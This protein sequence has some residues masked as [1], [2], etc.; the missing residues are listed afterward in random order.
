MAANP[1]ARAIGFRARTVDVNVRLGLLRSAD[2]LSEEAAV[3]RVAAHSHVALDRENEEVRILAP[4]AVPATGAGP[5]GAVWRKRGS[6]ALQTGPSKVSS[7]IHSPRTPWGH[8]V[9]TVK[10]REPKQGKMEEIP[11][12]EVFVV[13]SYETDYRPIF[14]LPPTYLRSA[15][16]L[17]AMSSW[18]SPCAVLTRDAASCAA[19]TNQEGEFVEYDLDNDDED[20]LAEFNDGQERLQPEMCALVPHPSGR[21]PN[22]CPA[23]PGH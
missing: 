8:Q 19:P 10:A 11:T 23:P 15:C 17:S 18:P 14:R 21:T 2:E 1:G 6:P 16:P 7:D 9:L 4:R 5:E 13:P 12:P 3:S 22:G 20:W